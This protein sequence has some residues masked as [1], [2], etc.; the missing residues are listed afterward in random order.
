VRLDM[1]KILV[2]HC[3]IVI[4][5]VV[6]STIS[7]S[8]Q[9]LSLNMDICQYRFNSDS[10]LIEIY[11]SILPAKQTSLKSASYV[12]ELRITENREPVINNLWKVKQENQ[13]GENKQTHMIVDALRYL[14][15]P[16]KYD[17]KLIAKNVEQPGEIDSVSVSNL[18]IKTFGNETVQMS[19]I[20]IAQKITTAN[21]TA[22]DKFDKNRFN[23]TPFPL[24]VFAKENSDVYYYFESYNLKQNLSQKIFEVK[25]V[26]FDVNSLPVPTI[27]I[28]VKKKRLRGPD[29][30]EVGSFKVTD[31]PSGK[32]FVNFS[33]LDSN[34]AEIASTNASFF[35]HNPDVAVVNRNSLPVETQMAGSEV[36]LLP[37][38]D[39]EVMIGVIKYLVD[40]EEKKILNKLLNENA[41]RIYLYRYW[42]DQ[43]S[44]PN[45]PALESYREMLRRIQFSNAN[46]ASIKKAG[47]ESD[48]GRVLIK[49]GQPS[50]IQYY[51]NVA[52]FKEFQAW[53]YDNIESGVVFIFGVLGAFGNL[54]LIHSS[55]TGELYNDFWFDL[56]RISE[57]KT[58]MQ[59]MEDGLSSRNTLRAIFQKNNLEMPRYLK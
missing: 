56:L 41:K 20:E 38:D 36:A 14:L 51:P 2:I 50:E 58:G 26:I 32:Y 29:D 17:F 47:W 3:F 48:R 8:Q 4:L 23:V 6:I 43:D 11:Y 27:P 49:Y 25:R 21:P 46:F 5:T 52:E 30:V 54:Q 28:Y 33:I 39:L 59:Q 42:K 12:L 34:S 10:S 55:K 31:L 22:I 37:Q 9:N 19:D 44:N 15:A 40:D 35:V 16:G 24:K 57:G 18:E 1:K 13:S 45:T 7:Y 53:S